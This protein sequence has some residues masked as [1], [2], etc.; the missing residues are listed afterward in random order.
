[1]KITSSS[2][3]LVVAI[4]AA[5][6]LATAFAQTAPNKAHL[7]A[8]ELFYAAAE[9]QPASPKA[10]TPRQAP[11]PGSRSNRPPAKPPE[12]ARAEEMTRPGNPTPPD[13]TATGTPRTAPAPASGAPAL[14]LRY[15]ILKAGA[16]EVAPDTIFHAGDR[17]QLRVQAN[18]PGYLY[19]INQGSS[20]TWKPMFPSPEVENGNN[21]VESLRNY[22]LPSEEHRMLFDETAGAE[23]LFIILSSQPEPDLEKLIYSLQGKPPAGQSSDQP[24]QSSKQM[25]MASNLHIDDTTVGRMRKAYARDLIIERVTPDTPGE[26]KETAVYVVN[27]SGSSNSR[28]VADVSLVHK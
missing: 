13:N 24:P 23:K 15:T 6:A 21:H 10:D 7:S 14:G 3:L 11:K 25:I 8:R 4:G 26:K 20:G 18:S 9:A 28:V 2:S 16:G 22:T 5:A 12:I 17:I 27:P 19:I 1:M